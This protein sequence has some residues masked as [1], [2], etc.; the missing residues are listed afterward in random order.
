MPTKNPRINVT[1]EE[2]VAGLLTALAKQENKSVAC[3]IRELT[4]EALELRED[5]QL[6]ALGSRLD[7]KNSKTY[8]HDDAWK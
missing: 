3:L 4:L 6:S 8:D 1:F 7:N 5:L 2:R